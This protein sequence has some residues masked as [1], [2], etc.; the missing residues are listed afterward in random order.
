MRRIRV[1]R[2]LGLRRDPLRRGLDVAHAWLVLALLAGLFVGVPGV[3][4]SAGDSVFRHG[5][6]RADIAA[7]E[8]VPVDATLLEDS[9]GYAQGNRLAV[10]RDQLRVWARWYDTAAVT[11]VGE[12]IPVVPARAG[13]AVQIWINSAGDPVPPPSRRAQVAE[14]AVGIGSSTALGFAVVLVVAFVAAKRALDRR[15][16]ASWESAWASIEPQW[17]GRR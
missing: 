3:A 14:K 10:V 5:M 11:H 16:F 8:R 13:D 6:S 7:Q 17:S 9:V 15:R 1:L 12:I 4:M 2:S